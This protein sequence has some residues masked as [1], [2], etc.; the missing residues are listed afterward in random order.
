MDDAALERLRI[1]VKFLDSPY[2][3]DENVTEVDLQ[4]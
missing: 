2:D 1:A 3:H 4:N